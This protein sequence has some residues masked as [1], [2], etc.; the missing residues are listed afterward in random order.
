M[1]NGYHLLHVRAFGERGESREMLHRT[2]R[3]AN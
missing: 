3:V 2:I 1:A